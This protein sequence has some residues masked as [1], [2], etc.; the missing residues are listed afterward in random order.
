MHKNM[1]T[2]TIKICIRDDNQ[3]NKVN[4]GLTFHASTVLIWERRGPTAKAIKLKANF[5]I[6]DF[7][8]SDGHKK[9]KGVELS[10]LHDVWVEI[11]RGYQR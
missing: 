4:F 7:Q 11:E 10:V 6:S 1:Q 9:L 3:S 2:V 8:T 5:M